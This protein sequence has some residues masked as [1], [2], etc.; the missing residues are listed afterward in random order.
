MNIYAISGL[1][2]DERVFENLE[3]S[4]KLIHLNWIKP[5]DNERIEDYAKRLSEPINTEEPFVILGLSFGG[6]IASEMNKF[7]NPQKTILIS[8]CAT[9][10]ELPSI[11]LKFGKLDLLK[12]FSN[13]SMKPPITIANI[14][15]GA[16]DKNMLDAILKDS[17]EDFLHWAVEKIVTWEN[18]VYP[19]NTIQICG[20]KDKTL[21]PKEKPNSTHFVEKGEHFMIYDKAEEVSKIIN[22]EL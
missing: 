15:F 6:M 5:L 9:K 11:F 4:S 16:K 1:G 12:H 7:L 3:I 17:D 10:S 14:A 22:Q 18:E 2:A 8:S 13:I 20:T 21:P 19:N